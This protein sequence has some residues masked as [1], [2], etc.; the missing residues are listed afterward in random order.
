MRFHLL[1]VF[2]GEE[3]T[4]LFSRIALRSLLAPGNLPALG[5]AVQG[6]RAAR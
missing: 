1:S 4:D 3:F 2:W 5:S 6:N